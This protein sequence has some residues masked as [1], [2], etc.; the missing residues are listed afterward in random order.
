MIF[1]VGIFEKEVKRMNEE[2]RAEE[3]LEKKVELFRNFEE[4][5]LGMLTCPLEGLEERMCRREALIQE[6]SG[7]DDKLAL[8]CEASSQG[9]LM[10]RVIHGNAYAQEVPG[11]LEKIYALGMQIRTVASRI[12]ELDL[13]AVM[14][15]KTEQAQILEKIK[16]NNRGPGAVAS[17]YGSVMGSKRPQSYHLGQA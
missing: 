9:E 5:T 8:C 4:V 17:R 10:H 14:R 12:T 2:E 15:M 3:L 16:K 13:Q 6:I 1:S 7:I 11:S